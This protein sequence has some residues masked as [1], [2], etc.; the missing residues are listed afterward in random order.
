MEHGLTR[1]VAGHELIE[2]IFDQRV[3]L[4]D[5]A[6]QLFR[7]RRALR[8]AIAR[9]RGERLKGFDGVIQLREL[10]LQERRFH[11]GEW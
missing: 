7:G 4:F 2:L 1:R 11:S 9:R 6:G 3:S 8:G 5:Q 10:R